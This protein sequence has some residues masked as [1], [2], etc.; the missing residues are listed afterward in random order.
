MM[1]ID[2]KGFK[3][4]QKS[5]KFALNQSNSHLTSALKT[6]VTVVTIAAKNT[7]AIDTGALRRSIGS[8]IDERA[9]VGVVGLDYPGRT[10]GIYVEKGTRPR[11]PK[12]KGTKAQPFMEPAYQKNEKFIRRQFSEAQQKIVKDMSHGN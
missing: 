12:G 5:I 6:A 9:L 8:N 2:T 11:G 1:K 4:F 3:E 10:Y 7:V